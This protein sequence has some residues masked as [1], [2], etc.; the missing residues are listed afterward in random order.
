M[1]MN[2]GPG[3]DAEVTYR[4]N[5]AKSDSA[6]HLPPQGAGRASFGAAYSDPPAD[7]LTTTAIS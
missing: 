5:R 6:G 2:W 1:S 3:A 4:M 7:D